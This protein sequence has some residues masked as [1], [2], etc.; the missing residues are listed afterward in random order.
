MRRVEV[1]AGSR[2]GCD[3][4]AACDFVVGPVPIWVA[5]S[6]SENEGET[7]GWVRLESEG[8]CYV[9]V[10]G[11]GV[12]SCG[13]GG[14]QK[15]YEKMDCCSQLPDTKNFHVPSQQRL[16]IF[17]FFPDA[18]GPLS[19]P[20]TEEE[21]LTPPPH[22]PSSFPTRQLLVGTV[23][24]FEQVQ[25]QDKEDPPAGL[26]NGVQG[27]DKAEHPACCSDKGSSAVIA[28]RTGTVLDH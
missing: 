26:C 28:V 27:A 19:V 15:S 23:C 12:L 2:V 1:G 20:A 4:K 7:E 13:V 5:C 25:S 3:I 9:C 24:R 10:V 21:V 22:A 14:R 11:L 18:R 6:S 16:S 17:P 8:D